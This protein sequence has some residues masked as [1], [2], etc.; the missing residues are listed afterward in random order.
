M[1]HNITNDDDNIDNL[2]DDINLFCDTISKDINDKLIHNILDANNLDKKNIEHIMKNQDFIKNNNIIKKR[3]KERENASGIV[4]CKNCNEE[5]KFQTFCKS[6]G[7]EFDE[8]FFDVDCVD[9]SKVKINENNIMLQ[10]KGPN[11]SLMNYY[12]MNNTYKNTYNKADAIKK[13]FRTIYINNTHV[14]DSEYMNNAAEKYI[15]ITKNKTYKGNKK[16]SLQCACI[17]YV[18]K[19]HMK[20]LRISKIEKCVSGKFNIG[21]KLYKKAIY[22]GLVDEVDFSNNI[23]VDELKITNY[24]SEL[25]IDH[26]YLTFV[27]DLIKRAIDKNIFLVY[28]HTSI[29]IYG[30]V[31]YI[32]SLHV[33]ELRHITIDTILSVTRLTGQTIL[34]CKSELYLHYKYI[35]KTFKLHA[36]PMPK[37][38]KKY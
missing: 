8:V 21:Y 34:K 33:K 13:S 10:I 25:K 14:F 6:C 22:D 18:Y 17:Y 28:P 31:I 35:K 1:I 16:R 24:L 38:W 4:I 32:L 11:A 23:I 27:C 37:S 3:K 19:S 36:I 29:T 5:N 20:Y 30:T 12:L 15:C 2:F 26:K 9:S 7:F